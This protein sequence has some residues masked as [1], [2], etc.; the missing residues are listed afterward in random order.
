MDFHILIENLDKKFPNHIQIFKFQNYHLKKLTIE[1]LPKKE[2]FLT[3][4]SRNI[5]E[6]SFYFSTYFAK[7]YLKDA[8]EKQPLA[9]FLTKKELQNISLKESEIFF[10]I[11]KKI[12]DFYLGYSASIFYGEPS[13]DQHIVAITGTNGKTTTSFMIYHLWKKKQIPCA[14]IGTL[15]VFYWN[16]KEEKQLQT[17]FTT[18]RSYQLQEILFHLKQNNIFF[19]VMEA[20]SEALALRRLEGLSIQ[21]S[22]FTNFSQDHLNFHK[23]MNAYFF[24]KLHLF[25]LT[26]RTSKEKFPFIVVYNPNTYY[27]FHKFSKLTNKNILYL[28]E[29]HLKFAF[30]QNQPN[31]FEFNQYNALCAY[32]GATNSKSKYSLSETPLED[33][34]GVPGRM[35]K[36]NWKENFN[37]Y[38]DYAH[39]PDALKKVLQELKKYYKVIITIFGCGG[40][41]DKEKRPIMGE[42]SSIYSDY[43]YITDDNPRNE[44][45]EQIRKEIEAGILNKERKYVFNIGNRKEAIENSLKKG[46]EIYKLNPSSIAILIAGKGHENYQIIGKEKLYFS[47]KETVLDIIQKLND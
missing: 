5:K 7:Q 26:I 36:I 25:F 35:E 46:L 8:I 13:K 21:K 31:N 1:D 23:S 40:D 32:Y 15:G 17:G 19:I 34:K 22:I 30:V 18:P 39:T 37:I 45:P 4:D 41:R 29:S 28:L 43:V 2:I 6:N 24:S 44:N 20:S 27:N 3:D 10:I 12:P 33:F 47:D 38:I 9:I 14:V 11:G 16:G 42:I